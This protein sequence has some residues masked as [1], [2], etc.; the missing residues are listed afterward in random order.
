MGSFKLKMHRNP[1][2]CPWPHWGSLRHSSTVQTPFG[3][4]GGHPLPIYTGLG[5][6]FRKSWIRLC[7]GFYL[8]GLHRFQ[9]SSVLELPLTLFSTICIRFSSVF[10]YFSFFTA[11]FVVTPVTA[12]IIWEYAALAVI[13]RGSGGLCSQYCR[14]ARWSQW[15][16]D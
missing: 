12:M 8:T 11:L 10:L 16:K 15:T 13:R 7:V 3:W 6:P 2:H 1:V 14:P 4:E 5:P 9:Q